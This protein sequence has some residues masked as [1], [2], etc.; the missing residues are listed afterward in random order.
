MND[1]VKTPNPARRSERA[2]QAIL[3][4][5]AELVGDVGYSRLTMEA[6]AARAG[7]GKQTIYRWWPDKGAL[8][9]D[10]YLALV[11]ADTGLSF[12]ESPD[13]AADLRAVMHVAADSFA[14]PAI[15]APYR[16]LLTAIQDDPALAGVLLDKLVKPWLA[17]TRQRLH[18]AQLAGQIS[19]SVNLEVA[20][21][22]L[23]GPVY[24][25]WLLRTG[26]ITRAYVDTVVALTLRALA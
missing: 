21:E 25:R 4:A 23:Y 1:P 14:A 8:I 13:L 22:L 7:V 24:Y 12:P 26:P 18:A 10:A 9:L 15:E 5:A 20:V 16:A 19:A 17:L 11:G 2:R 6:I 3:T